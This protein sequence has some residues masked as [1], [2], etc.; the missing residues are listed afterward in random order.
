MVVE[1]DNQHTAMLSETEEDRDECNIFHI[2]HDDG[3]EDQEASG[4]QLF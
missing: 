1:P 2:F 4:N 3:D